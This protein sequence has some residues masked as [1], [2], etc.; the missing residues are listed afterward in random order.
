MSIDRI[1]LKR[2]PRG[3]SLIE[4]IVFIVIV[5]IALVALLRVLN[6]TATHGSDPMITKQMQAIAEA[7]MEE[8][9][10][11]PFTYCDPEDANVLAAT[12]A[13]GCSTLPEAMGPETVGGTPETRGGTPPFNNVNDY[14]PSYS[15][16]PAIDASSSHT[17]PGYTVTVL[18]ANDAAL[19]PAGKLIPSAAALH[20]TVTV[21]SGSNSLTLEGY[22]TRFAPNAVQ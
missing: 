3:L 20:V 12:S 17:F 21:A 15:S 19:G 8:V 18:V 1:A 5:S 13:A 7:Y 16:N 11:M 9:T 10:S 22:R 14:G 6:T 4:L 2:A